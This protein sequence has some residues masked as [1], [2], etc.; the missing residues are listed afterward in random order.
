MKNIT[1]QIF[2]I[3]CISLGF[4]FQSHAQVQYNGCS[5]TGTY[6]SAIGNK[7]VASGNNSFAGGYTSQASGSNSF[8]FGYN[9][10][11]TQSTTTAIGNTATASGASSI[12]VGNYVKATAQNSFVFGSGTT[13]SYPLTNSTAYS[14]AFGVN[15]NK[16]TMLITKSTNNNYTGKVAIG[17]VSSPQAKLHIKSDNNEDAGVILEPSNTNSYKAFIRLFD[18]DHSISVDRTAT[19][20]FCSKT[21][22]LSFQGNHYCFGIKGDKK[23]FLFTEKVPSLYINARREK[24]MEIR[25][26]D[27]SSY[28]IDFYDDAIQFRT[29]LYQIPRGSEISN[30]RDALFITTDGKIGIG[31]KDTYL[32]NDGGSNLLIQAPKKM[33][34]QSNNITLSGKIGINTINNV[35][36]YALAVNGG[37]IST[38]VFIKEVNQWPDYVF[39]E[40]YKLL[41][42]GELRQYLNDNK[43][44]PGVPSEKE[45]L[46]NGYDIGEMQSIM[47]EKIEE[48]TRYILYLQDE[49]NQLKTNHDSVV[50]SYDENG[51][52]IS[53]GLL[54][55]RITEPHQKPES[56]QALSCDLFPNP[57]PGQFSII[58]KEHDIKKTLHATLANLSGAVIE[59]KDITSNQASFDLSKQPDGI[60]I[61]EIVSPNEHQAWKIIKR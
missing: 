28:A 13:A 5:T 10:K 17:Q 26:G 15:S 52:R 16:P 39:S 7:T 19:M 40:E 12:A 14:I 55:K 42:L 58:I 59:E 35:D 3:G 45:I 22:S 6:S 60:F 18:I 57:T 38:K 20:E 1:K 27:G 36:N 9:S 32:K 49:I 31:T 51:N 23:V 24:Q 47:M 48:M 54:F 56:T 8:A 46:G 41:D 50:F 21:G 25:E 4:F 61:L 37:M 44:L 11:A 43:H 2:L 33:D 53:R 30:W 34:L 29:A